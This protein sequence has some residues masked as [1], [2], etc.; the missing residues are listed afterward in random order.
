[1][2]ANAVVVLLVLLVVSLAGASG[3]EIWSVG[4]QVTGRTLTDQHDRELELGLGTRLL[5]FAPDRAAAEQVHAVL[6]TRPADALASRKGIYLADISR[7]PGLIARVIA[8]PRMRDYAYPMALGRSE[9]C[10]ADIPRR[11]GH[12]SLIVLDRLTVR[13]VSF[14]DNAGAFRLWLDRGGV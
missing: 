9:N 3:E 13:S 5:V 11:E 6:S 14:V 4:R 8:I 1:M 2:R 10:C 12:I 7:M